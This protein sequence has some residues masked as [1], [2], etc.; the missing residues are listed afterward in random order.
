MRRFERPGIPG[1]FFEI[2]VDGPNLFVR[3]G[4][5]GRETSERM[6][7]QATPEAA[8]AEMQRL[9]LA[10]LANDYAEVVPG[11]PVVTAPHPVRAARMDAIDRAEARRA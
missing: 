8:A 9:I 7:P 10:H 11:P 6:R 5:R 2:R 3:L 1:D 4:P